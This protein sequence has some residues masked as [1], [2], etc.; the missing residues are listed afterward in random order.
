MNESMNQYMNESVNQYMN[1]SMK[2]QKKGNLSDILF[3]ESLMR[4]YRRIPKDLSYSNV[5]L[6]TNKPTHKINH[7]GLVL[8]LGILDC[9]MIYNF[10]LMFK[11]G[12]QSVMT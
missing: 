10:P 1:E 12:L 2:L 11:S 5:V 4:K 6:S 3:L 7:F 9:Q 8:M